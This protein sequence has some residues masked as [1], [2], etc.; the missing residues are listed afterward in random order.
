M[1]LILARK[2]RPKIFNQDKSIVYLESICMLKRIKDK[3][4]III[5]DNLSIN[6]DG[7]VE[8]L[9]F[10]FEEVLISIK[11]KLIITN[12]INQKLID[13]VKFHQI[14]LIVI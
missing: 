6:D 8:E 10:F 13:I 5:I 7:T 1:T 2:N 9:D 3:N 4:N 12:T 11:V 14:P